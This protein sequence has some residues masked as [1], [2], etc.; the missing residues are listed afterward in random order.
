MKEKRILLKYVN[1]PHSESL[2]FYVKHDGYRAL[3][4]AIKEEHPEEVVQTLKDANLRGRGGAGFPAGMKWGF[5]AADPQKP[6][7]VI[8]NADE[9]EPGT[10]KDRVLMNKDPHA[11]LEGM[12]LAGYAIGAEYG[13][14]YL[15]GEYRDCH[16]SLEKA[17]EE[18]RKKKYLGQRI[19]GTD[20]NFD[21][22]IFIG[23]GAYICGEETALIESV[24]GKIGRSRIKPPF[25]VNQGLFGKPTSVNN[26]ETLACVPKII[27]NGPDWFSQIGTPESPGTKIYSISGHV[28][29]RGNYEL[30]MGVTVREAIYDAAGG[31]RD[32]NEFK[33]VLPGGSSSPV[34][35]EYHMDVSLDFHNLPQAGSMLGSGAMIVMDHTTCMVGVAENL[36]RF[37]RHESCGRCLPCREG[38]RWTAKITKRIKNF[39]ADMSEFE[40]LEDVTNK[41][42]YATFCAFGIAAPSA[43]VS[44]IKYF[45]EDF[46]AHARDKK[47]LTGMCQS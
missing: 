47:C 38:N 30:P 44:L 29:N 20:F 8:C 10:F 27:L 7:Y 11:V 6:K 9:G 21:I 4:M 2:D 18:A 24:E 35:T 39:E 16:I 19:Q 42:R 45:R 41:Y 32:D 25:P 28:K 14:I 3:I 12:A 31:I 13:I 43:I 15:R 34:L 26:V 46:E 5:C 40:L 37:Y 33:A 23:A 22:G 36:S 1:E 17:I